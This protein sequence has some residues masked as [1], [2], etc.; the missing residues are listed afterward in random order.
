VI[1]SEHGLPTPP[2]YVL[3]ALANVS[4]RLGLEWS[5]SEKCWRYTKGW[6]EDHPGWE[7]VRNGTL[8]ASEARDWMGP[9]PADCSPD[10]AFAWFQRSCRDITDPRE[11]DA[12]ANRATEWNRKA[13]KENA[14]KVDAESTDRLVRT[15]SKRTGHFDFDKATN[16]V[17]EEE[18]SRRD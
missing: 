8:P 15:S 9:L 3:A 2:T 17:R 6:R 4:P 12:I 7:R 16:E 10:E 14:A 5:P 13:E 1:L 11:V 18:L